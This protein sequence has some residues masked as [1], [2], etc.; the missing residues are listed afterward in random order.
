MNAIWPDPQVVPE[1][2][3]GHLVFWQKQGI[4]AIER[5]TA[6]QGLKLVFGYLAVLGCEILWF[7]Q[8]SFF[9]KFWLSSFILLDFL[10]LNTGLNF[11]RKSRSKEMENK[12]KPHMHIHINTHGFEKLTVT[13]MMLALCVA[14]SALLD[15]LRCSG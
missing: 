5:T 8:D 6:I 11:F 3:G 7:I 4:R 9:G 15:S 14:A 13:V 1:H 2:M 12:I 10:L